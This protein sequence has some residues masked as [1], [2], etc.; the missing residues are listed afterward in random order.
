MRNL[1]LSI[2]ISMIAS[3]LFSA[4][5][6]DVAIMPNLNTLPTVTTDIGT[7]TATLKAEVLVVG[8]QKIVEY[9]IEISKSLYFTPAQDKGIAGIPVKGTYQ[10]DFTALEPN[11][12]YYYKAYALI[13]T[14]YV[15]SQNYLQFTTKI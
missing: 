11:T 5:T 4:C 2:M 1:H 12:L 9:G 14:A 15:Y 13:N 6:E 8:N 3:V 7:T 10:V